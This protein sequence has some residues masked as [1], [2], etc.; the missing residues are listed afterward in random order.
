MNMNSKIML[1]PATLGSNAPLSAGPYDPAAVEPRWPG[2]NV[3]ASQPLPPGTTIDTVL[4]TTDRYQV[5]EALE[6][7]A[8]IGTALKQADEAGIDINAITG[9]DF[10]AM[11]SWVAAGSAIGAGFGG[12][13]APIGAI[14]ALGIFLFTNVVGSNSSAN[15]TMPNAPQHVRT[16]GQQYAPQS[17]IDYSVSRNLNTWATPNDLF[18]AILTYWLTQHRAVITLDTPERYYSGVNDNIYINGAGGEAV[19]AEM[20]KQAMVDYW[21][22]K[23]ARERPGVDRY[24]TVMMYKARINVPAGWQDADGD[25]IADA[26]TGT[27]KV[28]VGALLLAAAAYAASKA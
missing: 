6:Y 24:R 21:A 5:G 3:P 7:V 8:T 10:Q 28:V 12:V 15:A 19:V 25:G 9:I 18:R 20:Y 17:F 11:L 1:G 27:G 16:L 22:T 23:E 26:G 2:T 13:G 4:Q 14:V